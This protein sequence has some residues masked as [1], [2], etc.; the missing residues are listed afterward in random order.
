MHNAVMDLPV[1][2][3][4]IAYIFVLILLVIFKRRGIRRERQIIIATTRMTIQLT[5]MGYVLMFIFKNPSWWLTL[6]MLA[7]MLSFAI[8]NAYKRRYLY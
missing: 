6:G 2:N 5:L 3:L 1:L 4:A 8:Y 7:I